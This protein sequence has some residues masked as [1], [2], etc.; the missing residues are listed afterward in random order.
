MHALIING[1]PRVKKYSNTDKILGKITEGM[2]ES[3]SSYEQFEISDRS[4][5][6]TIRER[7]YVVDH[8]LIAL[9]LYVECIPGLLMEFLETVEPIAKERLAEEASNGVAGSK[10]ETSGTGSA[11]A[12]SAGEVSASEFSGPVSAKSVSRPKLAFL[13]QSGFAEGIQLRCGEAYLEMLAGKLACEYAGTLVKG[14]NFS[15]RLFEDEQ[16]EKIV[17]K[18]AEMGRIYGRD[19][20]FTDE[21]CKK[22]TGPEVFP[23]PIRLLVGLMF[24]TMAKKSFNDIAK[25]WGCTKPLT[26]RP[27]GK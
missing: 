6:D 3:G 24:K 16:R 23:L 12:G 17:G 21:E 27:Y 13:L 8:I 25:K 20:A 2:K 5:W 4:Q 18:Y 11:S 26:D 10:K 15:I 22:F 7:F 19:G 14:D 9:P 1:S